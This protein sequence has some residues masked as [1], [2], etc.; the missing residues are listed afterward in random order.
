MVEKWIIP[1]NLKFFNLE[2]YLKSHTTVIW[3]NAFTIKRGDI[4]YIYIGRP[5]GEIKYRMKV[6]SD[7]VD[8]NKLSQNSYAIPQKPIHN[9]YSKKDKYIELE[10]DYEY[11]KGTFTFEDLKQHGLGQVQMQ[12]RTSRRLQSY[13]DDIENKLNSEGA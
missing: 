2:E 8:N 1:C 13:I 7:S 12:A 9:F 4:A 5:L 3:R 11:P 6:I 10:I